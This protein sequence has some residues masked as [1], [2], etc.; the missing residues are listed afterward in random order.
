MFDWDAANIGHIARHGVTPEE[1]EEAMRD[2]RRLRT[3]AYEFE[4]EV[5]AG[6]LGMTEG[7]RTLVVVFTH[8]RGAFRVVTARL[9]GRRDRQRY[10]EEVR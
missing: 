7:G 4:G 9:A 8:R 10:M 2:F 5:R 6:I 3:P 1:A